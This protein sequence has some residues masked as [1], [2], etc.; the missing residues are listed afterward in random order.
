MMLPADEI[1]ELLA[2]VPLLAGLPAKARKRLARDMDERF[3]TSGTELIRAERGSGWFF[4]LAE[5]RAIVRRDGETVRTLEAGDHFGEMA[6]IDGDGRSA[7]VIADGDARCLAMAPWAFRSFV[8]TH[9][10][11]AWP[12][13]ETLVQ[14]LRAAEARSGASHED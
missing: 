7:T 2:G 3:V 14:R 9:P 5:G 11:V 1:A 4:I 8:E 12:L 13:M 10:E 6:I